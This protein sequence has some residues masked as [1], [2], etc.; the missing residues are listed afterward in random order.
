M[1]YTKIVKI[2]YSNHATRK[3]EQEKYVK[4]LKVTPEVINQVV[5]NP[6]L[7]VPGEEKINV[8]GPISDKHSLKVVYKKE[9]GI[10]KIITFFPFRTGRYESQIL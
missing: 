8:Y 7:T 9:K 4:Q 1:C 6:E 5:K 2:V 10:I 3:F